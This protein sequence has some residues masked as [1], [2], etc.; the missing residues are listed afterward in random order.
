MNP[1][2]EK[3]TLEFEAI[4]FTKIKVEDYLPALEEAI[5]LAKNKYEMIKKEKDISFDSIILAGESANDE[6]DH[7]VEIFYALHSAHCSDELEAISQEFSE[8]LTE[9][10]SN[11]V[12]DAEL[13]KKIKE[14]YDIQGDLNLTSV[15]KRVLEHTY[16]DF[17]KNGALLS[18]ADKNALKVIDKKLSELSLTFS[19]NVRKYTN[20]YLLEIQNEQDLEGM[21]EGV[22]EAAMETAKAKKAK[23]KY[24]FTLDFPSYLPF[25]KYCTNRELRKELWIAASSKAYG[26]E[27]DN[28]S[29][30]LET[31]KARR[32]RANILGYE[33][34]PAFIL[35]NRMAGSAKAVSS[36]LEEMNMKALPKAKEEFNTLKKLKQ[37]LSGDDDFR[38]YDSAMYSEILKKRELDFDDEVL[39]PYFK[40][41]N[42]VDGVF[43]VAHKLYGLN[44]NERKD[45]PVY[46]EDV[47]V[48][49]V[50]DEKNDH[51]GLFYTD[52]FPRAEKRPGAWMTTFRNAGICHGEMKRPFVTIVCNFT[53]PTATKPSLLTLNEVS[54]LFHEFGHALHGLM[55]KV[56][57]KSVAGTNVYWDFVELPSQVMENWVLEKEC[58]D[59]FA[60]HYETG[61]D[62]PEDLIKKVKKT[63]R[64]L[65]GLGT[66]RQNSFATLDMNW[67]MADP[68][69]VKDVAEFEKKSLAPFQLYPDEGIGSMS[70][71]FGHIFA[72]GY[73]SGYYSYKWAEVLDADAFSVF[74]ENGIFDKKTAQK[75][76]ENILEK[77][78]SVDPMDLYKAFKGSEPSP[79]ALLKRAGLI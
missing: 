46:H 34:H 31:I 51:V 77:G 24:A 6:L 19:E 21:P 60:K 18:E 49:E 68:D 7:V 8:K 32:D 70:T 11:I 71:S 43:T 27:F 65:Q 14:V 67:H 3:S 29:V 23:T 10:N 66:L 42:V 50:K 5:T 26:G 75:F 12:M 56:Q 37:E 25:M 62:M 17:T 30:V 38:L 59:I 20:A 28:R 76:K 39:K 15:Q 40:L 36:F 57:Y 69:R 44:F 47:R 41:E 78:G 22:L 33:D 63:E 53:K 35:E 48:F 13:F 74:K 61:A 58:L 79:D 64:F 73:S 52:F 16:K 54:T 72:G 9:F 45:I 1:L 2:L 4:D 55:T